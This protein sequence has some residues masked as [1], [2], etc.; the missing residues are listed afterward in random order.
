MRL[1]R[2]HRLA[3][4]LDLVFGLSSADAGLVLGI[5][6]AA[7]RK[8]LSRAR[9]VLQ[10]F[11]G[12]VC[13]VVNPDASCR[14]EKQ[15]HALTILAARGNAPPAGTIRLRLESDERR[16]ASHALDQV[17][18]MSDMAGVL[19]AHPDYQA[20]PALMAGIRA[21]L[22]SYVHDSPGALN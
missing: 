4:V 10:S 7:Y 13:G 17:M 5:E 15:M 22:G 9:Q 2:D 6:P 12:K 20:P 8:R 18:A 3:Y 11:A 19:R 21:V 1:D 14:C 16:A